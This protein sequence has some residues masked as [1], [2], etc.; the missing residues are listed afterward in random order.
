ML[1]IFISLG[2][3]RLAFPVFGAYLIAF[4][5]SKPNVGSTFAAHAGD[6][7]YGMYLFGW[8]TEQLVKQYTQTDSPWL[9]MVISILFA[10]MLAAVSCHLIEQPALR[11]KNK[12]SLLIDKMLRTLRLAPNGPVCYSAM[13]AFLIS[14]AAILTSDSHWWF[15]TPSLVEVVLSSVAGAMLARLALVIYRWALSPQ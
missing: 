14:T 7:S 2:A 8:P 4:L 15:V 5:G 10:A 3:E 6:I 9:L 1:A 11:L 12:T 13:V